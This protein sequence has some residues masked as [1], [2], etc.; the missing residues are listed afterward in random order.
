MRLE[1]TTCGFGDRCS[2]QLS[3]SPV[4]HNSYERILTRFLVK[5]ML[6]FKLAILHLLKTLRGIAFLFLRRVIATLALGAFKNYQ[7]THFIT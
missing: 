2:S 1:L 4:C 5:S 7:F 3:Y 6:V